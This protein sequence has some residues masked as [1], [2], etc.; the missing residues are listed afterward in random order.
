[1]FENGPRGCD[2]Q[3]GEEGLGSVNLRSPWDPTWDPVWLGE[4]QH[5]G[6]SESKL[7]MACLTP[8]GGESDRTKGKT[9]TPS[10]QLGSWRQHVPWRAQGQVHKG[11]FFFLLVM[12]YNLHPGGGHGNLLQYSCLE[13]PHGQRSLAGYSP[14][15]HQV[16]HN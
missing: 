4:V 5:L 13:N 3:P 15:G 7:S 10:V 2:Q 16:R 6:F 11:L 1:M 12:G 14:W 8:R 9:S